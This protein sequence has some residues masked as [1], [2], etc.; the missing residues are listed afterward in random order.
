MDGSIIPILPVPTMTL[1]ATD[2]SIAQMGQT[3]GTAQQVIYVDI[4][5]IYQ[6][7]IK[8][9][10]MCFIAQPIIAELLHPRFTYL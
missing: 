6:I 9:N 7:K 3:R 4:S 8:S 5:M 10:Q 1:Y 2:I